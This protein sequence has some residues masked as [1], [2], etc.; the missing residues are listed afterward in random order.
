MVLI[1]FAVLGLVLGYR[2]GMTRRGFVVMATAA[3]GGTVLQIGH[4]LTSSDRSSMT[5]LPLVV[6]AIVVASMVI[7]SLAR[8]T[9]TD[10]GKA[11]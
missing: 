10:G 8:R 6:G 5:M 3:V 1:L 7:G 9:A 2:L 11:A 4:L